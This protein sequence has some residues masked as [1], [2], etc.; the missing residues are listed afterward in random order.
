[1]IIHAALTDIEI[2]AR[3]GV[4]ISAQFKAILDNNQRWAIDGLF[5]VVEHLL[6]FCSMCVGTIESF[7]MQWGC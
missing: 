6:S 3:T 7:L 5:S 2:A 1:M 4:A